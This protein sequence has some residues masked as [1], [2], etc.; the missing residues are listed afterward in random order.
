MKRKTYYIYLIFIAIMAVA[1][2]GCKTQRPA[3]V[4]VPVQYK[5]RIVERLVPVQLPADSS[6]FYALL[7]CDSTNQ[8][9]LKE[10]SEE[11]T[12]RVQS[13]VSFNNGLLKYL[14]VTVRDTVFLSAK[15]SIIYKEIPV[16]VEIPV[17][18]N[19]LTQWQVLQIWAGRIL[20][21]AVVLFIV[22]TVLKSYLKFK[23]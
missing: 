11:K 9:I 13:Q 20:L 2:F 15:D 14:T 21:L 3:I 8:V 5:E 6:N 4:E 22:S 7:E 16:R 19:K 18:V 1:I 23:I 12:K 10:L 17:E